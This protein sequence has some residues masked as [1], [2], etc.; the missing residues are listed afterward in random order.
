MKKVNLE[1]A[2]REVLE[3]GDLPGD[4]TI[5]ITSNPDTLLIQIYGL[6]T[7]DDMI[8]APTRRWIAD[9]RFHLELSVKVD[10]TTSR[11]ATELIEYAVDNLSFDH[12]YLDSGDAN[13]EVEVEGGPNDVR[14]RDVELYD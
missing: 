12:G 9:V 13:V 4:G 3:G 14:V 10:A 7:E 1:T 5:I 6:T 8:V 11:E 2:L